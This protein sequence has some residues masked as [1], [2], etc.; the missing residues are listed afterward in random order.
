MP[1]DHRRQSIVSERG[2]AETTNMTY[3][4]LAEH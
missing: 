3:T 4:D 1:S 2:V